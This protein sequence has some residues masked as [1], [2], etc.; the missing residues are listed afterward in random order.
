M[1]RDLNIDGFCSSCGCRRFAQRICDDRFMLFSCFLS[2]KNCPK[3]WYWKITHIYVFL[4]SLPS[5]SLRISIVAVGLYACGC[6]CSSATRVLYYS[7]RW[8]LLWVAVEFHF[9]CPYFIVNAN[10]SYIFVSK[11]FLQTFSFCDDIWSL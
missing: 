10:S 1:S 5:L 3:P 2:F 11:C 6:S 4:F 8:D 7:R 9:V